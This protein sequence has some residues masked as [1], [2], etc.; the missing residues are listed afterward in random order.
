M[1][2]AARQSPEPTDLEQVID[3]L[4]ESAQERQEVSVG[5]ILD[6]VGRRSFG[7][8]L[9]VVGLI[10]ASPLSGIPG[11][12][13]TIGVIVLVLAFQLLFHRQQL[14]LPR[15]VLDRKVS[16]SKFDKAIKLSR[17][18]ARFVDRLLKPR[19]KALT[20]RAGFHVVAVLCIVVAATMPPLELLPFAATAAGVALTAFGLSLIAEDGLLALI[21]MVLTVGIVGFGVYQL[22]Q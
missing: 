21:A 11:L 15:W 12:P 7:P 1:N 14:W 3:R 2:D 10:A 9:V 6:S 13:S 22:I 4:D 8:V 19:L 16:K 20:H 17:G 5:D 18:P